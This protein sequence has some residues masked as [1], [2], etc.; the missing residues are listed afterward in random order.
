MQAVVSSIKVLWYA[1]EV[2]VN[3]IPNLQAF[4]CQPFINF[5][6]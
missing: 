4:A 2:V 5:C 1:G 3:F 6:N